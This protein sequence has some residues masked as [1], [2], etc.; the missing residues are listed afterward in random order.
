MRKLFNLFCKG[1]AAAALIGEPSPSLFAY[2]LGEVI[3]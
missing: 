3:A 2:V 1:F